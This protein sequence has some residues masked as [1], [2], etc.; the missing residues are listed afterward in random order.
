VRLFFTLCGL[1]G[2][3][4][5]IVFGFAAN[6]ALQSVATDDRYMGVGCIVIAA[7]CAANAAIAL[8]EARHD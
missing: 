7:V 6:A 5:T 1:L 2:L 8:L 4:G 3:L